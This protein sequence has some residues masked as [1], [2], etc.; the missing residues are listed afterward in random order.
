[1]YVRQVKFRTE[2]N[3]HKWFGGIM[4]DDEYI[5]CGCCGGVYDKYD[6]ADG[7]IIEFHPLHWV[8]ISD[9]IKGDD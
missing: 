9:A 7:T 3:P 2:D 8:D 6:V 5:I 1:M 4:I